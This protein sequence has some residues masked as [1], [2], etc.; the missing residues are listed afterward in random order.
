MVDL[1]KHIVEQNSGH[2]E[3]VK[4][5]DHYEAA[6]QDLLEKKQKGSTHCQDGSAVSQ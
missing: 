5:E 2:F 3:P 6:L 4:F 1:A